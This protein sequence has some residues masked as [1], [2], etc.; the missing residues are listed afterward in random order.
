MV[1]LIDKN[2]IKT[3]L[4]NIN[5]DSIDFSI[6]FFHWGKEYDTVPNITQKDLSMFCFENG[7]DIVIG[8]HPHVIQKTIFEHDS[9]TGKNQL[10]CYSLGNFLSNQYWRRVDG[11]MILKTTLQKDSS[12]KSI[13]EAGYYLTWIYRKQ[14]HAKR[15]YYILPCKTYENNKEFFN[16]DYQ[17]NKMKL[18]VDD[19]RK[20]HKEQNK[21]VM[22]YNPKDS[23]DTF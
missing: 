16:G 5:Q 6:V 21:G 11:G 3:D 19:S 23:T 13:P 2:T 10:V 1:N 22:E 4:Q 15:E 20:L 17:Y 8:S 9:I 18:F 12:S 7:A 14:T